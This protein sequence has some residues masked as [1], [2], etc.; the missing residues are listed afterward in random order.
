M[1]KMIASLGAMFVLATA[2]MGPMS[3]PAF[4]GTL[5][6][7]CGGSPSGWCYWTIFYSSGG[8]RNI[9]MRNGEADTIPG[10]RNGDQYCID[11]YGVPRNGCTRYTLTGVQG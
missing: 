2:I 5:R 10:L 3:S 4:A 9:S 7:S 1:R 8:Y 11:Y 6:F